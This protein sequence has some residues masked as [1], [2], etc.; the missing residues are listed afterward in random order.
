M[1]AAIMRAWNWMISKGA[2]AAFFRRLGPSVA[3][4]TKTHGDRDIH[5][6]TRAG[7]K[8]IP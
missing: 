4:K 3:E 5:D 8:K 2:M 6:Q 1:I 7:E